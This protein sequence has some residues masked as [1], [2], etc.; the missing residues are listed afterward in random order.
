MRKEVLYMLITFL[1]CVIGF[2]MLFIAEP[3]I[4]WI[5]FACISLVLF[6]KSTDDKNL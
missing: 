2:T 3:S 5:F 1:M 6:I 4:F